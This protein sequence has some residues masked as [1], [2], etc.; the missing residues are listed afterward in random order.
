SYVT[1]MVQDIKKI[2]LKKAIEDASKHAAGSK[3]VISDENY[4][5]EPSTTE[6]A[7]HLENTMMQ[8]TLTQT[9]L[10]SKLAQYASRFRSM[11]NASEKADELM[12]GLNREYNRTKRFIADE[13][14][15]EVING[16]SKAEVGQ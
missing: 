9:I 3:R 10:D 5:F 1:L 14:I 13:R 6:V 16:L 8:I 2:E 12:R 15:K 11:K 7:S 4:I